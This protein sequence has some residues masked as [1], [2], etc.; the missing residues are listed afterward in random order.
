MI[1]IFYVSLWLWFKC[2]FQILGWLSVFVLKELC[3]VAWSFLHA[4]HIVSTVL[5]FRRN[6]CVIIAL[7]YDSN[8][9]I[10]LPWVFYIIRRLWFVLLF[11]VSVKVWMIMIQAVILHS[12]PE[13]PICPV[14]WM[15]NLGNLDNSKEIP[16][17]SMSMTSV[18]LIDCMIGWLHDWLI[19]WFPPYSHPLSF[20]V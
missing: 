18:W 15:C 12:C 5:F 11:H 6:Y 14:H 7:S 9:H 17:Q 20:L 4:W 8:L 16:P 1:V 2:T 19:A 10:F 13:Y 3:F